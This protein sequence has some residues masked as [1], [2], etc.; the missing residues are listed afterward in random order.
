MKVVM[1]PYL[2]VTVCSGES[3]K[4][5]DCCDPAICCI[6]SVNSDVIFGL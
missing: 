5:E 6:N 1:H 2:D 4:F 3:Q